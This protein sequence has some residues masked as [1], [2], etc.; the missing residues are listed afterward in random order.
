VECV[1][2]G[3]R[4][5]QIELRFLDA[6]LGLA[7]LAVELVVKIIG[8]PIKIGHHEA[9]IG[10]LRA[11]RQTGEEA[12][13]DV[14]RLGALQ[15]TLAT[16][17]GIATDDDPDLGP[18]LTQPGDQKLDDGGGMLGAIDAAGP[19]QTASMACPPKT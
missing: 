7:P 1:A 5:E 3:T 15:Q 14:S 4:A 19:Q 8:R 6:I 18:S 17:T 13:L 11:G 9:R 2:T 10:P 12:A 16:E